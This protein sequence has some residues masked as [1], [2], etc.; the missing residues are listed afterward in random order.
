MGINLSGGEKKM[1]GVGRALMSN[2][3]MILL[4]EPSEGLAPM[5]VANLA[6]VIEEIRDKG[7]TILLADQNIKFCRR[8]CR[9][10]YI[11]EKGRI[12]FEDSM[13]AI[14]GNEDVIRKYLAL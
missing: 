1:L 8:V 14:W 10:G 6:Q 12:V 2:P 7:M 3:E 13:E 4:D 9:R 5:V 11:L